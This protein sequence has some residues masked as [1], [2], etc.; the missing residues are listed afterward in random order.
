MPLLLTFSMESRVKLIDELKRADAV[1]L[2]YA[3]DQPMTLS[4][5][6]CFWLPELRKLEVCIDIIH[7][8][9]MYFLAYSYNDMLSLFLYVISE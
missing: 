6:S 1:V 9:N 3:C 2:T 4:R 7:L 5:L 8:H